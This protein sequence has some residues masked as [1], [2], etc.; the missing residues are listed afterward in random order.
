MKMTTKNF[1]KWVTLAKVLRALAFATGLLAVVSLCGMVLTLI[2]GAD[3]II[4]GDS[5]FLIKFPSNATM[6][7]VQEKYNILFQCVFGMLVLVGSFVIMSIIGMIASGESDEIF[8]RKRKYRIGRLLGYD[9][10]RRLPSDAISG[11][12]GLAAMCFGVAS[13][14]VAITTIFVLAMFGPVSSTTML[15]I[16]R[17]LSQSSEV[18]ILT[19][20]GV[21]IV[22]EIYLHI[23]SQQFT[24]L[25]AGLRHFDE[26][27]DPDKRHRRKEK[28]HIGS[29]FN[30][31]PPWKDG[32]TKVKRIGRKK[33][34]DAEEA[35]KDV[36]KAFASWNEVQARLD[37]ER[38]L[39]QKKRDH[40][41]SLSVRQASA[42]EMSALM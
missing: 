37:R 38:K 41:L 11:K 12:R 26:A 31:R 13:A 20:I 21:G 4:I 14:A 19:A 27:P 42:G 18:L 39:D 16:V 8:G 40:E 5:Q 30:F 23:A 25:L 22:A 9:I 36:I 29:K 35:R 33:P 3:A 2:I 10:D 6:A 24:K 1:E 7:E 17:L 28:R 32:W 15:T 34:S